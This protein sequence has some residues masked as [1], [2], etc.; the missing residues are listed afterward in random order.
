MRI[1]VED[2]GEPCVRTDT[3]STT[4]DTTDR[5]S[6]VAQ[7]GYRTDLMILNADPSGWK[8]QLHRVLHRRRQR[9]WQLVALY[10]QSV[11]QAECPTPLVNRPAASVA[12]LFRYNASARQG[13]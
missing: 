2:L 11:A 1:E 9:G 4:A 10:P 13:T 8:E 6:D 7:S 5:V 3:Y 12:L